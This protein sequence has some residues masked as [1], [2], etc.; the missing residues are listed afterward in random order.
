MVYLLTA[1]GNKPGDYNIEFFRS[2][3]AVEAVLAGLNGCDPS[4]PANNTLV[5]PCTS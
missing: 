3:I 4:I 5:I 2:G 1:K